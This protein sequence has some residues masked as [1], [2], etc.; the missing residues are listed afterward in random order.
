MAERQTDVLVAAYQDI[1]TATRDFESL[2]ALVKQKELVI[3]GVILVSHA[4]DGSV[5]VEL[6]GDHLGRTG[7]RWGGGVGLAV[8]LFAPLLLASTVA[9]GAVVGWLAGRFGASRLQQQMQEKI[10]ENLPP[11]SA[12]VIAVFEDSQRLG[13]ER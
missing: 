11:G 7:A 6:T 10:G 5:S 13:V 9:T 8:G 12:G 4:E 1:T 3:E 2:V